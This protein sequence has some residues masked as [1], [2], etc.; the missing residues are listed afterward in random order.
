M[1]QTESVKTPPKIPPEIPQDEVIAIVTGSYEVLEKQQV[2]LG[3]S[4]EALKLLED[5][6]ELYGL[7]DR[8]T[9]LEILLRE[10]R[11]ARKKKRR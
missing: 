5:E 11:E 6:R 8:P 9:A 4:K 10:R 1:I 7:K 2:T 3:L